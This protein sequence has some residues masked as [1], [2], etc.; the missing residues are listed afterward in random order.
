MICLWILFA[1][2][3]MHA[4]SWL[5]RYLWLALVLAA[6][7]GPASYWLG[8]ELSDASLGTPILTSMIV[9]AAG[10]AILFPSGIYLTRR[11]QQ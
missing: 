7:L 3:F 10:W 11:Y 1:T 5:T 6:V 8:S 9:M 2:T 4:L